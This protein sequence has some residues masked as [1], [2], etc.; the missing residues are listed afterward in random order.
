M[1]PGFKGANTVQESLATEIRES[2]RLVSAQTLL[3]YP[4]W[5]AATDRFRLRQMR[6][7]HLP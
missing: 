2:S 4:Q 5:P 6:R 7:V 3:I 1:I